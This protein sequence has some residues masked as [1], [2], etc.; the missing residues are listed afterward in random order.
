MFMARYKI[1]PDV[2]AKVRNDPSQ[3]PV[4][5]QPDAPAVKAPATA[6]PEIKPSIP[7]APPAPELSVPKVSEV[8]ERPTNVTLFADAVRFLKRR[9]DTLSEKSGLLGEGK[10]QGLIEHCVDAVEYLVDL[11][12][13]EETGC[14]V[15]DAFIDELAEAADMMVLMQVE[16]GDGP[17]ADAATLLLQLRRDMEMKLAA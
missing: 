16:E 12:S 2:A 9:G 15:S 17:A 1:R 13:R 6:N 10:A 4:E 8:V 14:P 5:A 11:F 7:Y 3:K